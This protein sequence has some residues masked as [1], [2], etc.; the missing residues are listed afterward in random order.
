MIYCYLTTEIQK[1]VSKL[2][3]FRLIG[4]TGTRGLTPVE[5]EAIKQRARASFSKDATKGSLGGWAYM[6]LKLNKRANY[7]LPKSITYQCK[8]C[9]I[10]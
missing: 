5:V 7:G 3:E 9:T 4:E 1:R 10:R 8:F 2:F 6:P